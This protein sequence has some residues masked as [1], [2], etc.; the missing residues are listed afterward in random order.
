MNC[1]EIPYFHVFENG[2]CAVIFDHV[3]NEHFLTV[4]RV[5]SLLKEELL[6]P[7]APETSER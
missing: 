5:L 2:K 7:F 1:L 3:A 4:R 6:S